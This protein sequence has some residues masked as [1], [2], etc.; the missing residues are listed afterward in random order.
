[1]VGLVLLAVTRVWMW[2]V[3]VLIVTA[4]MLAAKLDSRYCRRIIEDGKQ[5]ATLDG[6]RG[7]SKGR[8]RVDGKLL[9]AGTALGCL[10]L[11]SCGSAASTIP[12]S[13]PSSSTQPTAS[14]V[15]S[16]AA[17]NA[18]CELVTSQEASHLAGVSV[19]AC[20]P[21]TA[22]TGDYEIGAGNNWIVAMLGVGITP[23]QIPSAQSG[24]QGS[25]LARMGCGNGV[26]NSTSVIV[27]GADQAATAEVSC[28]RPGSN[29][30]TY[31]RDIYVAK[32]ANVFLILNMVVNHPAASAAALEAQAEIS[33]GR[34]PEAIQV[35]CSQPG[36]C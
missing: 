25:M 24:A 14:A 34:L 30:T 6:L 22:N 29:V 2:S 7:I 27:P 26:S 28:V 33:L 9:A 13:Q 16:G 10:L 8:D 20:L 1:M 23:A 31:A 21:E 32:G 18:G 11:A 5:V 4:I 15:P 3:T 36:R 19:G 17:V 35:F 12:S